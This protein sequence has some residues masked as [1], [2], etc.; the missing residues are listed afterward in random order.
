MLKEERLNKIMELMSKTGTIKVTDIMDKL[1]VSDMTARRDL[2]ELESQGKLQRVHGGAR[3]HDFYP[4]KELTHVEKKIIHIEEKEK[5]AERAADFIQEGDTI[6]IGPG[7]TCELLAEKIQ[8]DNI[9]IVT[10]CWPVF[11]RLMK[12]KQ[13]R[14]I[15]LL[16]GE[17]RERTQA[18]VGEI[19]NKNLQD[20]HFHKAFF[21]CNALTKQDI[22]TSTIEEGQ[23]QSIALSNSIK[24]YLLIDTSKIGKTDFSVYYHLKDITKVIVNK[25]ENE[26]YSKI[27][28]DGIIL[29]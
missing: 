20:M 21:S 16:G 14:M 5:I 8:I 12:N 28:T 1:A 3:L 4:Q 10:N 9:R 15:Y 2:G 29:A 18:F 23:T 24:R 6:F 19:T 11:Q 7:T 26:N 17:M 27:E 13:N 22:M 25:D